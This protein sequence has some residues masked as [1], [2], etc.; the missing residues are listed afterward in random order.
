M[1][2]SSTMDEEIH[3][4]GIISQILHF[5]IVQQHGMF[6]LTENVKNT[7]ETFIFSW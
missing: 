1:N 3:L 7:H 4:I 2:T 6:G 5:Y